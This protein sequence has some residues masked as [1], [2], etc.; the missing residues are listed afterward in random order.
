[1]SQQEPLSSPT[2]SESVAQTLVEQLARNFARA[3]KAWIDGSAAAFEA[4]FREALAGTY[5]AGSLA[6]DTAEACRR[7][8]TFFRDLSP[9]DLP[10]DPPEKG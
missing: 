2:S 7:N 10:A 4:S 8:V 9:G 5:S 3:S 1:M 6:R